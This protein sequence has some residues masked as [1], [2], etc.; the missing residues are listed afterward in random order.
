[1]YIYKY[2]IYRCT[3]YVVYMVYIVYIVD[4]VCM[5]L[6]ITVIV[7]IVLLSNWCLS[8]GPQQ[9]HCNATVTY[10][11]GRSSKVIWL[12]LLSEHHPHPA[13]QCHA[14]ASTAC[15]NIAPK[16]CAWP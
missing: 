11:V 4:V 3:V 1:M 12:D 16:L 14:T 6:H 15:P 10:I 8:E 9:N 13:T 7:Y 5:L 2:T